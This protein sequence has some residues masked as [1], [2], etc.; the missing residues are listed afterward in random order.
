MNYKLLPLLIFVWHNHVQ[1]SMQT[2]I[3]WRWISCILKD[4]EAS[5]EGSALPVSRV[6]ILFSCVIYFFV[7][8]MYQNML[9]VQ[10]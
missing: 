5:Q 9:V 3:V 2:Y 6:Y 8:E 4:V 10:E 1:F 7:S